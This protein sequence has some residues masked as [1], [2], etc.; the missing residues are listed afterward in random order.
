MRLS[1]LGPC[2]SWPVEKIFGAG[3]RA[4]FRGCGFILRRERGTGGRRAPV[5][6]PVSNVAS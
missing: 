5:V 1:W 4:G 3:L 6:N 2:G